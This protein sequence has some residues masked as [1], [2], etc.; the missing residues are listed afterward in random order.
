MNHQPEDPRIEMVRLKDLKKNPRNPR[1]HSA[2]QITKLAQAIKRSRH[3]T[4][5]VLDDDN[6]IWA[7]HGRALACERNKMELVPV[8]RLGDLSEDE[9]LA[10]MLADN[11][12][13]QLA[14][15]DNKALDKVLNQL[16]DHDF[17]FSWTGYSTADLQIG[18]VDKDEQANTALPEILTKA[19]TQLGETWILGPHRLHCG[20]SL[21]A[22]SF[23][24]ALGGQTAGMVYCDPPYNVP[25]EGFVR[26]KGGK[27]RFREFEFASGEMTTPEFTAFLRSAFRNCVRFSRNGSIHYVY[28]D[29]RHIREILDAADGIYDQF[30]QLC[31]WDKGVGGQSAFYRSQYEL[32]FVFKSGKA[33]HINNFGLG[34]KGRYRTN[35]WSAPGANS[36]H[37]GREEDLAIHATKK[38]IS[39]AIDAILDC[40]NRGDVILDPFAGSSGTILAAHRTGRIGVGIEIDPLYVDAAVK[41]LAAII[42]C[43]PI[44]EGD[45]RTFAEIAADRGVG[46]EN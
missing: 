20:S 7:G 37:K 30:K 3:V 14:G 26:G 27:Q 21:D 25:I 46:L 32:V 16:F 12:I 23:E 35:L 1:T 43:D 11:Q 40:S 22:L 18:L 5:I 45:G 36:F 29:W 17:D 6:V 8:R 19:V 41:Y 13:Q 44:L 24:I 2:K 15:V 4:A 33:K 10:F 38:P 39:L 9:K 34:D 28:Q 31:V 42:G